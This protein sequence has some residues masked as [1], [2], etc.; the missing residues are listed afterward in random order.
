MVNENFFSFHFFLL[1]DLVL[2]VFL[3][4]V[5][6]HHRR[7]PPGP[8][9]RD[10]LNDRNYVL[11]KSEDRYALPPE[12]ELFPTDG[13]DA[14][15]MTERTKK[16]KVRLGDTKSSLDGYDFRAWGDHTTITE[17]T[18]AVSRKLR[19]PG[20]EV[21]M[22]T[23][24]WAKMY[25]MLHFHYLLPPRSAELPRSTPINTVHICEAPG[26]FISATN[27]FLKTQG[28]ENWNWIGNSL[29]PYYEG[30]D[31]EMM[32]DDDRLIIETTDN[33]YFGR[34]NSGNIMSQENVRGIWDEAKRRFSQTEQ[35]PSSSSSS[36]S[37]SSRRS[38][39]NGK[40]MLVTSD[41]SVDCMLSPNLQEIICAPLHYCEAVSALGMLQVD[42]HFVMKVFMIYEASSVHLAYLLS[43]LFKRVDIFKPL[44]SK[45]G[46][47]EL[48]FV[49]QNFRGISPTLLESLVSRVGSN[50]F[51]DE[52]RGY[53]FP[54]RCI[55]ER[56]LRDFEKAGLMFTDM[57][58]HKIQTNIELFHKANRA[59]FQRI[60]WKFA[61]DWVYHFQI[62]PL[63]RSKRLIPEFHVDGGH[64]SSH[65]LF[66]GTEKVFLFFF[67][68][69]FLFLLT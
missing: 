21:E 41:G 18:A 32:I 13:S 59:E 9:F 37:S 23:V 53:I 6:M 43:C 31:L 12:H 14:F 39:D 63:D 17:E 5:V 24:A 56:F 65:S 1:F 27:H 55:P 11:S 2:F 40:A 49:A 29:H 44:T 15:V 33:W 30:N 52:S 66:S 67:L 46:N 26:A 60:K 22:S 36:S 28:Y 10:R 25:E 34:D 42:G 4:V 45:S 69:L 48:Y 68:F 8:S 20:L 7:P 38:S 19:S 50:I 62:R 16:A 3:V 58:V 54:T 64:R 61:D 47:S 35:R 57:Q 51:E